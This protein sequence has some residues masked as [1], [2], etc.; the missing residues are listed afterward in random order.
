MMDDT[1]NVHEDSK[2]S[3]KLLETSNL[4]R[5]DQQQQQQQQQNLHQ[6]L[7]KSI[8]FHSKVMDVLVA[9]G[10]CKR[11]QNHTS[12]TPVLDGCM[13]FSS[14]FKGER[15][16]EAC[17]CHRSFHERIILMRDQNGTISCASQMVP[18]EIGAPFQRKEA[19]HPYLTSA[20]AAAAAGM[21]NVNSNSSAAA[22]KRRK[23]DE[24]CSDD[25]GGY[26]DLIR[27][28]S[29]PS[30]GAIILNPSQ[31][32]LPL[33]SLEVIDGE[34]KS[35]SG[36]LCEADKEKLLGSSYKKI[37]HHGDLGFAAA[38]NPAAPPEKLASFF[39]RLQKEH[40]ESPLKLEFVDGSWRVLC[41]VCA[42]YLRADKKG[43]TLHNIQK[44]HFVTPKH[45]SNLKAKLE[46]PDEMEFW[47]KRMAKLREKRA[48]QRAQP[49]FITAG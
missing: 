32:P 30:S 36:W 5:L 24:F 25:G 28:T 41:G 15:K 35:S 47:L 27:S 19:D 40:P 39:E 33:Q 13:E 38:A 43:E 4:V 34:V 46:A 6:Q 18:P 11:N 31:Q 49:R 2:E 45:I 42:R 3:P 14:S 26:S 10:A 16:C 12:A 7:A 17:G 23:L 8:Q 22:S 20:A 48:Q 44:Q 1:Q 37:H 21:I 9:Y 29:P